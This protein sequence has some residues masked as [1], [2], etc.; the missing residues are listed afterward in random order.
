M[1]ETPD[2]ETKIEDMTLEQ[3]EKAIQ[4]LFTDI[5]DYHG[6]L[7]VAE[8]FLGKKALITTITGM[9]SKLLDCETRKQELLLKGHK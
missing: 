2:W 1:H 4:K 6:R 9:L 7:M 5:N 3:L 8:H